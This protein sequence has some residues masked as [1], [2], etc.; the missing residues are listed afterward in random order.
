MGLLDSPNCRLLV[1]Y[2]H[3]QYQSHLVLKIKTMSIYI[4]G[5][6][7]N[8]DAFHLRKSLRKSIYI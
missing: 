7:E 4:S 2:L 6:Y 1:F 8:P 5:F 3:A